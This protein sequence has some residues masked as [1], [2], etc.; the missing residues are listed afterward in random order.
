MAK[1][2]NSIEVRVSANTAQFAQ[3]MQRAQS[4][5]TDFGKK[6]GAG[7]AIG[8]GAIAAFAAKGL[9]DFASFQTG[10]N[11]VFTLLPGE[12]QAAFDKLTGQ[13]KDFSKEFG[14]LP[15]DVIPSLYQALSAGVPK[16]N[17]FEFLETAQM[18]AKGGVTSLETAVDGISSVVNSYGDDVISATEASDL[19]FT[20]VRLGKTNFE[21]LSGSLFQVA[22]IASSLGV[23]FNTVTASL[24]NLTA[25]GTPT[26]V[27]ATQM[28]SALSELGKAGS[29]ADK[30]FRDL[31]GI[32]FTE[33]LETEGNVV[34]A[35]TTLA[36]GAEESGKSVLDMFGSIEAGQ[37]VLALTA[38]GGDAFLETLQEMGDSAGATETAFDTM[39][40]GLQA[41]LDRIKASLSV[42]FIDV[43]E[44][45]APVVE[46]ALDKIIGAW[47][48]VSDAYEE[49]GFA[50]VFDLLQEQIA[51]HGPKV[52]AKLGGWLEDVGAWFVGTALPWL[53]EKTLVLLDALWNWVSTDGVETLGKLWDWVKS[54][55]TW[56]IDEGLPW[57]GE[58]TAELADALW[59]WIQTDGVD[60][61]AKLWDW[62]ESLG[63]WFIDEGVP[64]VSEKAG[65]LADGLIDWIQTDA[66]DAISAATD[67]INSLG[68]WI[69]NDA[70]DVISEKTE[71][72]GEKLWEWLNSEDQ[73][74]DTIDA[75]KEAIGTFAKAFATEFL[76]ALGKALAE[77]N[78]LTVKAILNLFKG[79]FAEAG[80]TAADDFSEAFSGGVSK[81][82]AGVATLGIPGALTGAAGFVGGLFS[83]DAVPLTG[84]VPGR[85]A[86]GGLVRGG[87]P[88]MIGEQGPEM[89]VPTVSGNVVP[90][91]K[92]RAGSG[93]QQ[94]INVTVNAGIGTDGTQV[95]R[96]IVQVLNEYAVNGGS[97]LS[98]DLVA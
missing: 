80:R 6:V 54:V 23:N 13:T 25:K 48:A 70:S 27:A 41:S 42:L 19:M 52:L 37:A 79:M 81:K 22:P 39:D 36:E 30:N 95:G 74:N 1:G 5:I 9:G 60:T 33:F 63:T 96:Q 43:G 62:V 56:F 59:N 35:F 45:L 77:S 20:A 58:K 64:Y 92:L 3:G 72:L 65:E 71:E 73:N 69:K 86:A 18:A 66:V 89:F 98:S 90:N 93:S 94:Q 76:P 97:R 31:T 32:G 47:S 24:A 8:A 88:Y 50:G 7:L 2:K 75:A 38:D 17:V 84:R 46:A 55:G 28:K 16:D 57:L 78:L 12:S 68:D 49:D 61:I 91:N 4:S 29:K 26:K 21:E 82:L 11:E 15:N 10:M 51:E 34:S 53:G 85:R 87:M 83:E 14:V 40:T 44:K 67:W